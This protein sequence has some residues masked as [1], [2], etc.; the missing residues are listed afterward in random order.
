MENITI[1]I[2]IFKKTQAQNDGITSV[3]ERVLKKGIYNIMSK[4]DYIITKLNT[5]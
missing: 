3:S 1:V 4:N 2:F 5:D